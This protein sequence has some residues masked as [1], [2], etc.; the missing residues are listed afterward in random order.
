MDLSSFPGHGV[1]AKIGKDTFSM[2]Y[3]KVDEIISQAITY[4]TRPILAKFNIDYTNQI[5]QV[6]CHEGYL[7]GMRW[8]N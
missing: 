7:L 2:L 3:I 1:N 8:K 5:V 4:G 6:H